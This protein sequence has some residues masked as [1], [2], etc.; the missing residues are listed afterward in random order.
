MTI[1]SVFQNAVKQFPKHIALKG[2]NFSYTYS[3]FD[4]E[5]DI[6]AKHLI[7]IG[8]PPKSNIG[9]CLDR[10]AEMLVGIIGILKAGSAYLPIDQTNPEK[11]IKSI[12]EDAK[13]SHIV[14]TNELRAFV[15]SLGCIPVVPFTDY[16]ENQDLLP[17]IQPEDTAYVLF[18]SGSTGTPKGVMIKH[19]SVTNLVSYI[20]K[21]YPIKER[22]V[23]LFKSPYTFDGSVWE[24]FGWIIMGGM[25]YVAP[26]GVEKDPKLLWQLLKKEQIAIT[27]FVPSMLNAFLDYY[28]LSQSEETLPHLKWVSVGGE[29]LPPALVKKFYQI[30]NYEQTKLYNVYGP[31]ETTIYATTY[32]C[33]PSISYYELPVG[34][35]VT[36]DQVYILDDLR[37]ML[38]NGET[39]EIYIGGIGV[40][41]GYL[42]NA[43]LNSEKF[44]EDTLSGKGKLYKTGDLGT[45]DKDGLVWFKGRKDYQV[46]LRGLRIELDEI[47][48]SLETLSLISSAAVLVSKD[49]NNL[50]SVVA[51][52]KIQ[53]QTKDTDTPSFYLTPKEIVLKIEKEISKWLPSYMMPSYYVTC[54]EFP[55]TRHGKIDRNALPSLTSITKNASASQSHSTPALIT[56]ESQVR[57]LW[58]Q[59]LGLEAFDE[60][61]DFFALGGHSL[62]AVHLISLMMK[63][64]SVEIPLS[65]FYDGLTMSKM[66]K[67]LESEVYPKIV[68]KKNKS[69]NNAS[70]KKI[71]LTPTQRELWFLHSFDETG[72][73]HNIQVEFSLNGVEDIE[74]LKGVIQQV[75]QSEP[76]FHSVF[77]THETVPY[78]IIKT[79]FSIQIPTLDLS[80]YS[81]NEKTERYEKFCISNGNHVFQLDQLPLFTLQLVKFSDQT[82]KMLFLIHHL[83]FDG[84][85]LHLLMQR[86]Q[87]TLEGKSS[88]INI[89]NT[90]EYVEYLKSSEVESKLNTQ[91]KY[92][93]SELRDAPKPV[94]LP[95]SIIQKTATH[96]TG[97][98]RYWFSLNKNISN[99][100]E[101]YALHKG[102]TSFSVFM[103]AYQICLAAL[104]KQNDSIVGTPFA[105]RNNQLIEH[106]IGYYTNM[107]CIRLQWDK[108][109]TLASVVSQSKEKSINA[110]SNANISFGEIAKE[111]GSNAKDNFKNRLY[112][113]ILVLQNWPNDSIS[114]NGLEISQKE[115][116]NNSTKTD[117]IFCIENIKGSYHCWIEYPYK[118]YYE[119]DVEKLSK[120][121]VSC[122][123]TIV[124]SPETRVH[125]VVQS[126][127]QQWQLESSTSCYVVGSGKLAAR[128]IAILQ[129][130]NFDVRMLFSDDEWLIEEVSIKTQDPKYIRS[131]SEKLEQVDYIFSINN[132]HILSKSFLDKASLKAIN[133]HD[134]PLPFYAGM[135]ATNWA[136]LEQQDTHGVSWHEIVEQI[137]AGAIL[138]SK[139]VTIQNGETALS[140]NTK[141]F[142]AAIDTFELLTTQ[143]SDKKTIAVQQDLSKRTYYPLAKRPQHFACIHPAMTVKEVDVLL[144]A[145][146]FGTHVD[147]EFSLPWLFV[148]NQLYCVFEAKVFPNKT[149]IPGQFDEVDGFYGFYCQDGFIALLKVYS[150]KAKLIHPKD[151]FSSSTQLSLPAESTIRTA[152]DLLNSTVIYELFWKTQIAKASFLGS[153]FQLIMNSES[154]SSFKFEDKHVK[155]LSA[156]FPES[157]T[158]E[159][160]ALLSFVLLLRLHQKDIGT[161]AV[162]VV[163][164]KA[165]NNPF[166]EGYVPF[167]LNL[168]EKS[169][170]FETLSDGLSVLKKCLKAQ[171]YLKSLPVRYPQLRQK[172][173]QNPEVFF[174]FEKKAQKPTQKG[175]HFYFNANEI[176]GINTSENKSFDFEAFFSCLNYLIKQ[177]VECP[178]AKI[179]ELD[180]LDNS[181]KTKVLNQI[182]SSSN[183]E[184]SVT[185]DVFEQFKTITNT[186]S[187]HTAIFS[188]GQYFSYKQFL[189]DIDAFSELL[190][191]KGVSCQSVVAVS[192]ER[193]YHYFVSILALLKIEV[194]FLPID[195]TL[196]EKRVEFMLNDA[197]TSHIIQNKNIKKVHSVTSELNTDFQKSA[198]DM[199]AY[200]M[201]TSGSTGKPKGVIVSRENLSGFVNSAVN[202]Y[203]ITARDKILQFSNLSFDASIEEVFCA[204][205]SGASL[206]LR[207]EEVM[208]PTEM[209]SFSK[210]H[211]ISVWDLPTAYWRQLISSAAY[212][213]DIEQLNLRLVII[214]GEAILPDDIANWQ[215][216]SVKHKLVNTYG[217]TE[218]TVVA[219]THDISIEDAGKPVVAIGNP[220]SGY[221]V[222]IVDKFHKLL[223]LGVPGELLISGVGVSKGYI[224]REKEQ[225]K[226]FRN[227][228]ISSA[229]SAPVYCSG[230]KVT[231]DAE[232]NVYY[233]GRL[234]EQ[235]KIRGFRVEIAEIERQIQALEAVLE[236]KILVDTRN[237]EKQLIGFYT[238]VN[239]KQLNEEIHFELKNNLPHYMIP[240]RIIH[241]DA[242]PL[243]SN[244][245]M[246]IK[247]MLLQLEYSLQEEIS[248]RNLRLNPTEK[249][250]K[251]LWEKVLSIDGIGLDDDFF[252][253]GGHSLKAVNLVSEINNSKDV[254]I[255]LSAVIQHSTLQKFSAYF[256]THTDT[257]HW[258]C[259]VPIRPEGNLSP[260]Y[261]IHG[262]G[263]NILL[264]QSMVN[265]LD[266][267]RQIYAFQ[268]SGVDGSSPLQNSI[269]QMAADYVEELLD[270]QPQGPYFLLGFS[271]GGFIAFEMARILTERGKKC[272]FTGIIDA[273]SFNANY[274]DS[275]LEKLF[276]TIYSTLAKQFYNLWLYYKEPKE[277]RKLF[278]NKKVKNLKLILKDFFSKRISTTNE[279]VKDDVKNM[280]FLSDRILLHFYSLLK[281]YKLRDATFPIDLFIAKKP[282]F[283]IYNRKTY[284]W[285]RFAKN[286]L[287]THIV[288][289]EHSQIFSPP[290]DRHFATILENRL[291]S[292]EQNIT[293]TNVESLE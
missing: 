247:A 135:Y 241:I 271:L 259:L 143:I 168:N 207:T 117:L 12:I 80:D 56:I 128:C 104:N 24:L 215:K 139:E 52:I 41:K 187:T 191:S 93:E 13:I 7:A 75:F 4:F 63:K 102:S 194:I 68:R 289:G 17:S 188:G 155:K 293:K 183:E 18:T 48:S 134:A 159:V 282:T 32:I 121:I 192:T 170:L 96:N 42:N 126:I 164:E 157:K 133:Y 169:H 38:P 146:N 267:E 162:E 60:S 181:H 95:K 141:C 195:F 71:P 201:Y 81:E 260:V 36:N 279:S 145:T 287:K 124:K 288:P 251:S 236:C 203:K 238:T 208:N 129:K 118:K 61:Q 185:K 28:I 65:V 138:A 255:P 273:V 73:S 225:N 103:A 37:N 34:K 99:Q 233:L 114:F 27:F 278:L 90:L 140:L 144:R 193:T 33:N 53:E 237:K 213:K 250:M 39:G 21:E 62:K 261:L 281:K 218:T 239:G 131:Q 199:A 202:Q 178:K 77:R 88:Q 167:N 205:S 182:N 198:L 59:V 115:I 248:E 64:F 153:S 206:F 269:E 204:F 249:W 76:I 219:L 280:D 45:I 252:Q 230:D 136:L 79:A 160:L 220:L 222:Y 85:S 234:D 268:A 101:T 116:G 69:T 286:G 179:F 154:S 174:Y 91:K 290:N 254:N 51:Y 257:T 20:Q 184:K 1:T 190:L 89:S 212:Q 221:S 130:K 152:E 111:F 275:N 265:Y 216:Q 262:A 105:N 163:N 113:S 156:L 226:A 137:D 186:Y 94:T 83:I 165:L 173:I 229:N 177:F 106:S 2:V 57:D 180:L 8:V 84:W 44:V 244:G 92:W 123:K 158:S 100:I 40:A 82:Y 217:P 175:F 263:L 72:I 10:S 3:Q 258:K 272:E 120:N 127:Q 283:F 256:D 109:T 276:I 29:V 176:H 161:V 14:T 171:T 119:K 274:S 277:M 231:T 227:L 266:P 11:R 110:F 151:E 98:K 196:P 55:L 78:Q 197:N 291:K 112:Q 97:G 9:I 67:D 50:D 284:G 292:I 246:D 86:I 132:S 66:I 15:S 5:T 210:K 107:V 189:E 87:N 264:Y 245:K 54:K 125:D 16:K 58:K 243:T 232:G 25:L 19:E 147:N 46:K 214:G 122:L 142:E 285:D 172:E 253:L 108:K 235:I 149:S 166:F 240:Q 148:D 211:E 74:N 224:N 26:P 209:I 150:T 228:N 43:Q 35:P 30:F 270:L 70:I 23:V 6:F 31:T 22:E 49:T 47:R 242:M 223:P 200:I